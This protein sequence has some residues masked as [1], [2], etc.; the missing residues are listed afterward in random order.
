[1]IDERQ[2]E[3]VQVVILDHV[4]VRA[5]HAR[6]ELMQ[7]L[8]LSSVAPLASFEHFSVAVGIPDRDHE[9]AIAFRIE[10]G[11]LEI[12]LEAAEVVERQATKV[13]PPGRDAA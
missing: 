6:H 5:R 8:R 4:R 2:I 11:R 12:E 10:P 1:M 9:H 7:Q 13:R 3:S